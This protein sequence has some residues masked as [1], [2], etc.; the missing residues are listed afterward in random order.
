M[1]HFFGQLAATTQFYLY[2][3]RYCTARGWQRAAAKY[4]AKVW[5]SIHELRSSVTQ[6]L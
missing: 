1:G 4:D 2:G 6:F 5:R 3:K